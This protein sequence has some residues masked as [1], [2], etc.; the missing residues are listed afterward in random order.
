V[1]YKDP[2]WLEETYK[3]HSAPEMAEM[4]GVVTSTICKYMEKNGIER[5][6]DRGP[7][8]GK[9][10]NKEW[11]KQ[12]YVDEELSQKEISEIASSK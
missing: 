8:D 7:K 12:K 10:K 5:D 9:H 3:D 1:R 2:E 4:C 11:L 6:T